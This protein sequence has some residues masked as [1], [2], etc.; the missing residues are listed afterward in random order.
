MYMVFA[1]GYVGLMIFLLDRQAV[2]FLLF[3][4]GFK[5]T[6][7]LEAWIS[8][9]GTLLLTFYVTFNPL[10]NGLKFLEQYEWK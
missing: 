8:V 2:Q 6:Y 10:K 9:A 3:I 7:N 5:Q 4:A 1:L